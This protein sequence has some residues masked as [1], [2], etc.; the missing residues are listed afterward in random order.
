MGCLNC[1]NNHHDFGVKILTHSLQCR[2]NPVP[3]STD[4]LFKED[5][6]TIAAFAIS[7]IMS[8]SNL[9]TFWNLSVVTQALAKCAYFLRDRQG[10]ER[11][12]HST[13]LMF[14][15]TSF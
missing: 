6:L 2:G 4:T 8:S 7:R 10:Q 1:M 14:S 5:K 15:A 13:G 9:L 3:V 11:A 12:Q